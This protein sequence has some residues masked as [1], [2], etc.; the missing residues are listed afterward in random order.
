M[1]ALANATAT[2]PTLTGAFIFIGA[3]LIFL[4]A[5]AVGAVKG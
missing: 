4:G 3:L 1:L 5:L 2:H